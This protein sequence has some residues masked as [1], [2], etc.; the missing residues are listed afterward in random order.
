M[1]E[2]FISLHDPVEQSSK[3]KADVQAIYVDTDLIFMRPVE[4]LWTHFD[5]FDSQQVTMPLFFI[6]IFPLSC[7]KQ[8]QQKQQ[9]EYYHYVVVTVKIVPMVAGSFTAILY[10]RSWSFALLE[11]FISM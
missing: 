7:P 2:V 9:K 1:F 6:N 3:L 8:Q 11:A 5:Y 4:D 10:T